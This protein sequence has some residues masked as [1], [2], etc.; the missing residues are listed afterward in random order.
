MATTTS[1]FRLFSLQSH[2]LGR[3]SKIQKKQ[4][5]LLLS[6]SRN[7]VR[8]ERLK[9]QIAVHQLK[10]Q[11]RQ[12]QRR[13]KQLTNDAQMYRAAYRK[14][15]LSENQRLQRLKYGKEHRGKSVEDF[16]H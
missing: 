6:P 12:L 16:W 4:V 7:P 9:A 2:I 13:L 3:P 5:N 8:N 11:P 10:I 14:D 15:E 1:K